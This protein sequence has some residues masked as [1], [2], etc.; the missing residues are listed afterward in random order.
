MHIGVEG[1]LSEWSGLRVSIVRCPG[2]SRSEHVTISIDLRYILNENQI[3]FS[4]NPV[5]F[6]YLEPAK[7]TRGVRGRFSRRERILEG[8]VFNSNMAAGAGDTVTTV[9]II[10]VTHVTL[11][12][13]SDRGPPYDPPPVHNEPGGGRAARRAT[14]LAGAA[15]IFFK[16][17]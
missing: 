7:N 5:I 8:K 6:L 15:V 13:E 3:Y 10:S 2:E 4:S 17:E 11:V 12:T 16:V 1:G 14:A 9:I